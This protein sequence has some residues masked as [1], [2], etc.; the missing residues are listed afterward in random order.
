MANNTETKQLSC[1]IST[2]ESE[3]FEKL[4]AEYGYE[5]SYKFLSYI[6][7]ELI[8]GRLTTAEKVQN[9]ESLQA[10]NTYLKSEL[11]KAKEILPKIFY[12]KGI[13]DCK[14]DFIRKQASIKLK[15]DFYNSNVKGKTKTCERS[16]NCLFG[17]PVIQD[18]L[19]VI[20][21]IE[22]NEQGN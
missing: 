10:E 12:D 11:A 6:A 1:R 21:I 14:A 17:Q 9:N 20:D 4:A 18:R 15:V 3:E 5:S 2:T 16:K 7:I 8:N 13:A 19:K 22:S